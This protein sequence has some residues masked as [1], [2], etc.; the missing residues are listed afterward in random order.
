MADDLT[1]AGD[2]GVQFAHQSAAVLVLLSLE[3]LP[4]RLSDEWDV[5]VVNAGTRNVPASEARER[6]RAAA[7]FTPS[8]PPRAEF[9]GATLSARLSVFASVFDSPGRTPLSRLPG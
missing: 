3:R 8:P 7:G 4:N 6:L 5:V 9:C 2:G 1:G